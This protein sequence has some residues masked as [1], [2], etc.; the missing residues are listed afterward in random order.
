MN[1]HVHNIAIPI[2]SIQNGFGTPPYARLQRENVRR[3]APFVPLVPP[4]GGPLGLVQA[5]HP[6]RTT[7]EGRRGGLLD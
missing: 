2:D 6:Q 4:R 5:V 1:Q 3:L 7:G